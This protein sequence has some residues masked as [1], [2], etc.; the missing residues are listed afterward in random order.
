MRLIPPCL[1]SG[2]LRAGRTTARLP[3]LK[4]HWQHTDIQVCCRDSFSK[5]ERKSYIKVVQCL[6]KLPS[7]D[8]AFSAA[9]NHFDDYVAVHMNL[10]NFI[11]GTANFLPWHRYLIHLWEQK[12][13]NSCG[14]KGNLPVC[15]VFLSHSWTGV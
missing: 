12:L 13:K 5:T 14:Y 2:F 10:T 4:T 8:P 11:H 15:F 6:W 9:Q 3:R 7:V 1:L